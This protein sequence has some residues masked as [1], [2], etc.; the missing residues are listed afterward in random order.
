MSEVVHSAVVRTEKSTASDILF[1]NL[2]VDKY[3]PCKKK[4]WDISSETEELVA[5]QCVIGRDTKF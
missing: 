3:I 4:F 2:C 5:G 1:L